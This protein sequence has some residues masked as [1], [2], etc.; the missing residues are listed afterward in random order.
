MSVTAISKNTRRRSSAIESRE[1]SEFDGLWV[2]VGVIMAGDAEDGSEDTFVRLPRG[3]AISDLKETKI[4]ETTNPEFAAQ[5]NL[6]NQLIQ[7]IQ[8]KASKLAEG[9]STRIKLECRLYRRQ[10][11]AN[12]TPTPEANH[13]L[14]AALF[15]DD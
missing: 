8:S 13:D 11:E 12:I 14:E 2:N 15:G 1:E 3:I 5:A 6:G 10:D 9:E 7:M 4:Y